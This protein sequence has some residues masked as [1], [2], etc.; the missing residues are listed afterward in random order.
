M[1]TTLFIAP[2]GAR[3]GTDAIFREIVSRSPGNN[4]SGVLYLGPNVPYLTWVRRQFF[5]HVKRELKKS[6]Y[7]PFESRTIKQLALDLYQSWGQSEVVSDEIRTLILLKISMEKNLGYATLLSELYS[8]IKHHIID[9]TIADVKKEIGSLI[10]E[11]KA[12]ERAQESLDILQAYENELRN[13]RL[14]DSEGILRECTALIREHIKPSLLVIDGFFDPTP[15]ETDILTALIDNAGSTIILAE[16]DTSLAGL[17][18]N[19]SSFEVTKLKAASQR[20]TCSYVQYPSIEEEVEGIV[21]N[22]KKLLMDGVRPWEMTVSFP[23]LSK[24]VLMI[25]RVCK[26]HGV[27]VSVSGYNQTIPQPAVVLHEVITCIEEDYPRSDFLS[28]LTSPFF[29][30]IPDIVKKWAVSFSYRAGIIQGREAWRSMERTLQNEAMELSESERTLIA[31]FQ[32]GVN[33]VIA[34]LENVRNQRELSSF[35]DVFES[36][37]DSLG[38]T[39]GEEIKAAG[40]DF[41]ARLNMLFLELRRF[42]GLYSSPLKPDD[43]P[44]FYL[45]YLLE[46]IEEAGEE[47]GGVRVVPFHLAAVTGTK[48]LFFGGMIEGDFPSKPGI[49]PI[50]PEQVKKALGMPYL[51]YYLERQRK[52]FDRLKNVSKRTPRFSCPAADG[53]KIFL[54]SPFLDWE[55]KQDPVAWNI[56]SDEEVLIR[57]GALAFQGIDSK[58]HRNGHKTM[59]RGAIDW[60]QKKFT[61]SINV[62][63]IDYYRKCPFRFYIEKVLGLEI[64]EPPRYEVEAR[65]WGAL[66]HRTMEHLF[67]DGDIEIKD[68]EDRLFRALESG[69]ERF[70]V[71]DF[72]SGVAR[73]IF[74]RLIP[75]L[76]ELETERKM[77]GYSPGMVE[78]K[79]SAEINGIRLKGKID[80]VDVKQQGAGIMD[81]G[82]RDRDQGAEKRGVHDGRH[83]TSDGDT[84]RII[85]YKTGIIDRDSLQL[86]LYALMWKENYSQPV[87]K[88]GYYSLKEAVI[89]WYPGKAGMEDYLSRA[90]EAAEALVENMR[91]GDFPADPYR[92]AECRY[93]GHGPLCDKS[94]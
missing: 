73:D 58:P 39:D 67:H 60:I 57:E 88:L 49:D 93:C 56:Y 22:V 81:R 26:K 15:L 74:R 55:Q 65:L 38:Y 4:F 47:H 40:N 12:R 33:G 63:D 84:V 3:G 37:L 71:G 14:T 69:L 1:S 27:P 94:T 43:F 24:Y 54:P 11:E 79:L 10:I 21:K 51:E 17:S 41:S 50:L 44:G 48:E 82:S 2:P 78:H 70:P 76:K 23:E 64:E 7:I 6:A 16:E 87:N 29:A 30:G 13:K 92:A 61:G 77:Q 32:E 52:Y 59:D 19:G 72:W 18:E 68:L 46:G 5:S 91:K 89:T 9:A 86:P 36:A 35:I 75:G 90:F 8:K 85:D 66:S 83:M 34:V 28:L 20:N 53:E 62:T 80:R 31:E 45:R 42:A 25:K